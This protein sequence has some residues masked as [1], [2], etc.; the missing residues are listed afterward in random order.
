MK[1]ITIFTPT[2]NRGYILE[3][4][5]KSLCNQTNKEFI[6]LIVDDG[7]KDN[8]NKLVNKWQCEKKINI[9]YIYKK[10]GGKYTAVNV[11]IKDCKTDYFAFLDSDDCYTDST[12]EEFYNLIDILDKKDNLAGIVAR[13]KNN[14]NEVIGRKL[15]INEILEINFNKLVAKYKFYGDTCR[16]YKKSIL[17]KYLYPNIAEKFI[18]EN[19]M[20][21]KIDQE[22]D[23]IFLNKALSISE[24]LLDGYTK[25]YTKLLRDNPI[26]FSLSLLQE[27]NSTKNIFKKIKGIL[28]YTNWCWRK[29]IQKKFLKIEDKFL[30]IILLPLSIIIYFLGIPSW[31]NNKRSIPRKIFEKI[32]IFKHYIKSFSGTKIKIMN[33]YQTI[34]F[35]LKENKSI[36]R[37]GDGEFKFLIGEEISYQE[38]NEELKNELN[39]IINEYSK[40]SKYLLCVPKYFF[41]CNGIKLLKNKDYFLCWSFPRNYFKNHFPKN[42]VYGDAFSFGNKNT[43]IYDKL[44]FNKKYKECIFVHN[45][46][47]YAENFEKKYNIKT[48]FVN[49]PKKN[50][51][52][53]ILKIMNN[54]FNIVDYKNKKE[55]IIVISAG[56]LGKVLVKKISEHG[57]IAID[58]GHC[59]D[60]PLNVLK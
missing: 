58:T 21:S 36:I 12:V 11:G 1:R 45:N 4:C 47:I 22:Y 7:S 41:E 19:V 57:I 59:W 24:Y 5:Y 25:S 60:K 49:I 53:D 27:I 34:D 23:I 6:W 28:A 40:T 52:T 3:E 10:N 29:K 9:E 8:T 15:D 31:H 33:A 17:L 13:R 43:L 48:H 16:I 14:N 2:Y 55:I 42:L 35:T 50:A 44:F 26:G 18:P 56:P 54:I 32:I 51:Y 30:Y 39:K 46:I 38:Y 37:L 20:L